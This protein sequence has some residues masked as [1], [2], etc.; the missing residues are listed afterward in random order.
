[1]G[2]TASQRTVLVVE[3][4]PFI[5]MFAVAALED[6]GFFVREAQDSAE[7]LRMLARNG[8]INILLTDVRTPGLMA[9]RKQPCGVEQ[10]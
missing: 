3:D 6:E 10:R 8:E 1:M 4:D 9:R 7:A 5:R 2:Q